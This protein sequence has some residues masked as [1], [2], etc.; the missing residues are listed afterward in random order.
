MISSTFISS[1]LVVL[2][3]SSASAQNATECMVYTQA[4]IVASTQMGGVMAPFLAFQAERDTL[5]DST[6]WACALGQDYDA[7]ADNLCTLHGGVKSYEDVEIC[8]TYLKLLQIDTGG[9]TPLFTNV[10]ICIAPEPHCAAGTTHK[11]ILDAM[12]VCVPLPDLS[13]N[14]GRKLMDVGPPP[15]GISLTGMPPGFKLP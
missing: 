4:N 10:P 8:E 1:L 5:C 6:T 13:Q 3:A 7:Q 11:D 9:I 2:L 14:P 15:P 12:S